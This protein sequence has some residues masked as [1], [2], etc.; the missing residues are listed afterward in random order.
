MCRLSRGPETKGLRHQI[1]VDDICLGADTVEELLTLQSELCLVLKRAGLELKKWSSNSMPVLDAVPPE[2]RAVEGLN[3][4]EGIGEILKVL[5]LQWDPSF[6]HFKFDVHPATTVITKRAILSTIA[7]IFD[8]IG[9]L[10]PVLFY[11]KHIMHQ[12][13]EAELAWDDPLP[14]NLC[15]NWTTFTEEL[16]ILSTI[17]ILRYVATQLQS[18][19]Q[20]CG[21]CDASERGYAAVVYL[22]VTSL[23]GQV[24][25]FLLGAKTK[26]APMKTITIPKLELCATVLLARWMAR[27][28]QILDGKLYVDGLF[29]WS[30]SQVTLSWLKN[31]HVGFKVF[32]SNRE[33]KVRQLLPSCQ[34]FYIRS[35]ENP[36]DCASR[37]LLPSELTEHSLYWS[38]PTFLKKSIETWDQSIL[39]IP[40]EQLPELKVSL[41]VQVTP[42]VEWISRFSSYI[43]MIKVVT[44]MLNLLVSV[45]RI[46]IQKIFYR[47]LSSMNLY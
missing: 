21:F 8:P 32:I 25:V 47:E 39:L 24:S 27:M 7:R 4:N 6:D 41:A 20:L 29:A 33:H 40:V 43:N 9:L 30:D 10:A 2:D 15:Q 26:M 17:R 12:I 19:V 1:Y 16:P 36:A 23:T 35:S 31:S 13:W 18:R 42:E 45:V 28:H 5:G 44:W 38:G 3:F 22:R 46:H 14:P 34:W 37:G 11:A